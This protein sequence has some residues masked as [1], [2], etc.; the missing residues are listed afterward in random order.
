MGSHQ[1]GTQQTFAFYASRGDNGVHIHALFEHLLAE[2]Q[3]IQRLVGEDRN[4]RR[5]CLDDLHAVRQQLLLEI[6]RDIHQTLRTFRVQNQLMQ[7]LQ[8]GSSGT[9]R[10]RSRE[11]ERAAYVT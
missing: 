10:D 9:R 3:G 11:D 4:D 8:S 5:R 2:I 7:R 1:R 6:L